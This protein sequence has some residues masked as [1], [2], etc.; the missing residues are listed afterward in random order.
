MPHSQELVKELLHL[1]ARQRSAF[2]QER[3]YL[4][5]IGLLLGELMALG[6]HRVTDLLRTLGVNEEDWSA[7][8]RLLK[9]PQ[10]FKAAVAAEKFFEQV[11][12][13]VSSQELLVVGGDATSIPRN[14][15][16]LEGTGWGKCPRNPP[17]KISIHLA[18]RFFNGCWLAPMEHG[19][20]R[21]IPLR[22]EPA[23]TEKTARKQHPA[24]KEQA[25][26]VT[27]LKWVREGLT[28]AG[29]SE[30]VILALLDGS[31]DKPDFWL[32]LPS[33]TIA[34]VRTAKNRALKYFPEPYA[35]KGRHRVYGQPAPA[36]QAYLAQKAG[37]NS[38]HVP[39]RGHSRKMNYRVEGPFLRQL[40]AAVPVFLICVRGQSWEKGSKNK[41]RSPVYYLVNAVKVG[42]KWVLP[43]PIK[44]LLKW[45][46][47]RWELEVVHREVKSV[48]GL[49]D[50]QAFNPHAAVSSVQW[51]AWGYANLMLAGYRTYGLA[52]AVTRQDAW[53]WRHPRR[54]TVTTLLDRCRVE[55]TTDDPF[56]RL[57]SRSKHNW[58][59]ME[60]ILLDRC[61][62]SPTAS[63]F[64]P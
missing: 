24:Q 54:W 44:T 52:K 9:R 61:L 26:A 35:G 15:K 23:F 25:A 32:N 37:W 63:F 34:L 36:P 17:F 22:F 56:Q 38:L 18:Q 29:R 2:G 48:F 6:A 10:R 33:N 7:W 55:L 49:G 62:P 40:M 21:A 47:Q 19:F 58:L 45:A 30:Q 27:F 39:V 51:S 12:T 8:Y 3:V 14:S 60:Q 46:W 31:Y 11:L 4:R 64:S 16:R 50:K 43:L 5:G 1:V 28:C 53:R 57:F 42:D 41:R 59:E 20:S 13:H